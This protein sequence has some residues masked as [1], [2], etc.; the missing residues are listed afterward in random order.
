MGHH[1]VIAGQ[2]GQLCRSVQEVLR[3]EAGWYRALQGIDNGVLAV[4]D[5]SLVFI[6]KDPKEKINTLVKEI[7]SYRTSANGKH[8]LVK[9]GGNYS[10]V[11]GFSK[12]SFNEEILAKHR[13]DLG[14]MLVKINPTTEWQQMY[15]E[16]WRTLRDWF[17]DENHHG[18]D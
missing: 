9:S 12:G 15:L 14:G 6:P 2:R 17:Y 11:E 16:G 8:L 3:G 13:I 5:K 7:E 4:S 1:V 10:L 18:Q